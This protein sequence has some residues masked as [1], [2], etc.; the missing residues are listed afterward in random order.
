MIE[1][2][3]P[4]EGIRVTEQETIDILGTELQ[5]RNSFFF[6]NAGG[7]TDNG[8]V[9]AY[10]NGAAQNNSTADPRVPN[11][12][13][14]IQPDVAPLQGSPARNVG[15]L[16]VEFRNDPFFD[17]VNYAGGV[18]GQDPWIFEGWTTFSDN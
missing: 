16:P 1:M 3:G 13:S 15:Q 10:L 6:S 12:Q 9:A 2:L 8:T 7:L 11:A 14:L 17:N 4:E 5:V 18:Q